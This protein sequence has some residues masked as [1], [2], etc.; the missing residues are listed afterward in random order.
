M[1]FLIEREIKIMYIVKAQSPYNVN[2]LAAI[3]VFGPFPSIEIANKFIEKNYN[4]ETASV[5]TL[6]TPELGDI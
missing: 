4:Q 1:K 3:R 5:D 6:I 2:R